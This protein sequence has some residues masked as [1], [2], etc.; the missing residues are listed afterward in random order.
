[1]CVCFTVSGPKKWRGYTQVLMNGKTSILLVSFLVVVVV[2][3]VFLWGG[4]G[5]RSLVLYSSA[6]GCEMLV[7]LHK[8]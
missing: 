7:L 8:V 3:F 4:G 5:R 6:F 2:V 1:M